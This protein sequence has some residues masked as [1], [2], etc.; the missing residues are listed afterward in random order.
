MVFSSPLFL[1]LFLPITLLAYALLPGLKLKN[2]C[3]LIVS[4]IFYGWGEIEFV[5][6][7]VI[8]TLLNY[9]LGLRVDREQD[10]ARRKSAVV[11]A[12]ALNIGLLAYFKYGGFV[13]GNL[14]GLLAAM[15]LPAF[16]PWDIR[17]PIGISFF[18]FH[19][20]SYARR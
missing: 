4:L 5:L 15:R 16:H 12:I 11:L 14:N 8:S 10:P 2:L 13:A 17:L 20:L 1:F 18:T 3:L 7:L 6:L 19:A 9:L